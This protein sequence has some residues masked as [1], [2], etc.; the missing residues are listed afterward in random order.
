M[1]LIALGLILWTLGHSFGRIAPDLRQRLGDPGKG[2]AAVVIF[3]GLGL[4][5]WGYRTA[6]FVPLWS[7]G[8]G[9]WPVN[10][11]MMLVAVYFYA[12]SGA[13]TALATKLRHPMLWGTVIWGVAHLLVNGDAASVLLFGGMTAWA[14]LTRWTI[15]RAQPDWVA[16]TRPGV[17]KESG[18]AAIS[19]V[20]FVVF[21]LIHGWIGPDPIWTGWHGG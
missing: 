14:L 8:D 12:V 5:I 20:V 3:A 1:T 4:M 19:I 6:D 16:P 11:L 10:N 2:V 9:L 15:N 7:P 13:R 18:V 21:S 17:G